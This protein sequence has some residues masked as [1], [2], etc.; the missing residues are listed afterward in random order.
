[1]FQSTSFANKGRNLEF[2]EAVKSRDKSFN[3]LPSQTKEEIKV[4][5]LKASF[6][7]VSIHFLRKQR[8]KYSEDTEFSEG[9]EV[10]IHFLRKQ[11]KKYDS[12][13]YKTRN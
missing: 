2:D 12:T 11:R 10:S 8:K 4:L 1:M 9:P 7:K 3:P 6:L 5:R 13:L